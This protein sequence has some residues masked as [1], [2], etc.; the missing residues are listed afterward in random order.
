MTC[1][2]E[3]ARRHLVD[4]DA[5]VSAHVDLAGTPH[6]ARLARIFL[7]E[8]LR[9]RVDGDTLYT[10]ELLTSELVTNVVLHARSS[11]H[12]GLTRDKHN[13]VVAVQDDDPAGPREPG[14]RLPPEGLETS[15]RGMLI[16]ATLADD[17]GWERIDGRAGKVMWFALAIA[18]SDQLPRQRGAATPAEI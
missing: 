7:R 11:V 14:D 12:V 18:P 13:V 10:A 3:L 9:G 15:G 4:P 1:E 2:Q 16:I 6:S 8:Q 5:A 17:F